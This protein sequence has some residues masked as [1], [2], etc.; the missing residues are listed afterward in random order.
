[1]SLFTI[2]VRFFLETIPETSSRAL[3]R[4]D[5]SRSSRHSTTRSLEDGREGG[6]EGVLSHITHTHSQVQYAL[7]NESTPVH[8]VHVCVL[9]HNI[10]ELVHGLG[11]CLQYLG[12]GHQ[13]QVLEVLVGILHKQAQLGHT[14]L[15]RAAS[16]CKLC[17][18]I[19]LM[20]TITRTN[21]LNAPT[22]ACTVLFTDLYGG[23]VVR[24]P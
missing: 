11:L 16:V 6:R 9:Q 17:R 14:Q 22:Y 20:A 8:K 3:T 13:P 5:S 23:G 1:M 2:S 12:H 18:L 21:P 10:L 7:S 4:M 24:H 19:Y 15:Q